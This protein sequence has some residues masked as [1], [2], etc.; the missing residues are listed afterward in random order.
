MFN[1]FKLDKTDIA[2]CPVMGS[3]T[4][5]YSGATATATCI[6]MQRRYRYTLHI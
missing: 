2:I 5:K 6:K 4:S 1:F 3:A